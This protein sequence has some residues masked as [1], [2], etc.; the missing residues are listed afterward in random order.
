MAQALKYSLGKYKD[1]SLS[2]KAYVKQNKTK[3]A[4]SRY[5]SM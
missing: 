3:T 1:L 4:G 5:G 2:P